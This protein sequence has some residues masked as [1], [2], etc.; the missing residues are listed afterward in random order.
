M[1]EI[2]VRSSIT[3][4]SYASNIATAQYGSILV[5]IQLRIATFE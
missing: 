3:K 1:L 2:M 4:Q 5:G